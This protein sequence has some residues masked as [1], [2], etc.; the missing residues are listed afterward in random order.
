MIRSVTMMKII[1]MMIIIIN[2]YS[3]FENSGSG[4]KKWWKNLIFWSEEG[5]EFIGS[6]RPLSKASRNTPVKVPHTK[7]FFGISVQ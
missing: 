1:T 3:Y 2:H 5:L 4:S 6:N 7:F